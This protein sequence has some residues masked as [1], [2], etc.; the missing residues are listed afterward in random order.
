MAKRIKRLK[1]G[2]ESLE[3]QIK[4][5]EEKLARAIEERDI[6]LEGYYRKEIAGLRKS[7]SRKERFLS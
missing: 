4:F 7:K 3:E 6:D 5:H 2:I 1:K